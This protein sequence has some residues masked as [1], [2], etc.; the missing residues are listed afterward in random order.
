MVYLL[1]RYRD[2][3]LSDSHSSQD[4]SDL[5]HFSFRSKVEL[6]GVTIANTGLWRACILTEI[7]LICGNLDCLSAP[8]SG[9]TL[10][11]KLLAARA[12]VTLAC[13]FSIVSAICL[14]A[15]LLEKIG[16]SRPVALL[17]KGLPVL[18]LLVGIIGIPIGIT[19]VLDGP[20]LEMGAGSIVAIVALGINLIGAVLAALAP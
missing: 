3:Y 10:C 1:G 14:L 12:F 18:A 11:S 17:S 13:I 16:S 7:G 6:N 2:N 9:T 4:A 19:T 8:G 20:K 15:R 5:L